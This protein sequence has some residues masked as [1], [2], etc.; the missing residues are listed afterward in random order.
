V[1]V[2]LTLLKE[3]TPELGVASSWTKRVGCAVVLIVTASEV[4][5]PA[6]VQ[7]RIKVFCEVRFPVNSEPD[8]GLLP[9]Q[10]PEAVQLV[11]F[12]E[13]QERVTAVL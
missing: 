4:V 13:V 3:P 12:E 5:P 7:T 6:P 9:D 1:A 8:K 11:A 10:S 2:K